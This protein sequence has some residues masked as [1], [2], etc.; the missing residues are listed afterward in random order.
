[1]ENPKA[2][3][4]NWPGG[5]STFSGGTRTAIKVDRLWQKA[6]NIDPE[7]CPFETKRLYANHEITMCSEDGKW[8]A[9]KNLFTPNLFHRVIIPTTCRKWSDERVRLLGGKEEIAKALNLA[10]QVLM[11]N[12]SRKQEHIVTH[13]GYSAG[14]NVP[15]IHWHS[16]S[17]PEVAQGDNPY[18]IQDELL[19]ATAAPKYFVSTHDNL[20]VV[21]GGHRAGQCLI[22]PNNQ[23]WVYLE[24]ITNVLSSLVALYADKFRSRVGDKLPP[25]FTV[26]LIFRDGTFVYGVYVPILNNMGSTEYTGILGQQA[27]TLPWPHE[28]TA[29]YLRGEIVL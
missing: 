2:T 27:M 29:A 1:M 23:D 19:S 9:F 20:K 25:D 18:K 14:Q 4:Q 3:V 13:N 5:V 16:L 22:L 8:V 24:N 7:T 28:Q 11:F 6:L 10:Y 12:P 21:V 26:D 15:H 17:F